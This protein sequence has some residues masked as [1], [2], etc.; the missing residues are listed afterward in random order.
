VGD[1][2]VG[3]NYAAGLGGS[4][5]GKDLGYP[6]VLYLDS[7]EKRYIDEFSTSNFIAIR[8]NTYITPKSSSILQSITNESLSIIAR[9]MGMIFERRPVEVSE[10]ETFDEVGA[11]GTAAVITPV[12]HIR[13]RDRDYFY[14]KGDLVGPV[15][16]KL[17]NRLMKLQTDDIED[18]FGWLY[19]IKQA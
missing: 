2:K 10:L 15:I 5:H 11:V 7:K 17:Y 16:T 8:D 9:D 4:Q 19:E 13:Y 14:G 6:V 1:C 12:N 3:G 18:K